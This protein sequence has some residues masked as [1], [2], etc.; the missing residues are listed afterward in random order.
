MSGFV[1]TI[2]FKWYVK[3]NLLARSDTLDI[4]ALAGRPELHEWLWLYILAYRESNT[5]EERLRRTC[6]LSEIGAFYYENGYPPEEALR[7]MPPKYQRIYQA[8]QKEACERGRVAREKALCRER[9]NAL[10]DC[11]DLSVRAVARETGI[12]ASGLCR[13]LHRGVDD[14]LSLARLRAAID[15]LESKT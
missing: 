8:Y 13:F 6:F 14:A 2:S 7:A 12:D 15:C 5:A 4:R 11:K 1:K 9:L 3:K 10:I